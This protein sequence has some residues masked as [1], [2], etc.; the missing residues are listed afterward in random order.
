MPTLDKRGLTRGRVRNSRYPLINKIASFL[1]A[2][3][4]M[5]VMTRYLSPCPTASA[6]WR[7]SGIVSAYR[8][9]GAPNK[10]NPIN[11]LLFRYQSV[12]IWV[13]RSF[14]QFWRKA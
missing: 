4:F 2:I 9:A 1:G 10:S 3:L 8:Q 14:K 13:N 7:R 12:I 11:G 6:S 5:R